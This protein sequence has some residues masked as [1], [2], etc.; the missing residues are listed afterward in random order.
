MENINVKPHVRTLRKVL[1]TMDGI[2]VTGLD[3][4][5]KFVGCAAA[6]QSVIQAFA[7]A[8]REETQEN[9]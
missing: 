5:D 2:A 3:N 1:A 8:A 9:A 4:Q 7:A 6:I